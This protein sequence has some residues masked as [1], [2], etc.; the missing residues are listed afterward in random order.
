MISTT[1]FPPPSG[2]QYELRSGAHR[3]VVTEVGATLRAYTVDGVDVIDGFDLAE[4]SPGGRGQ[5]LAPWPNRVGDGRYTFGGR[6][7]QAALNEP[8]R[9]NAIHGLVRWL[10]WQPVSQ[11]ANSVLL[12][13]VLQPQP[14]YPWRLDLSLEYSVAEDGLTVSAEATNLTD[15]TA[16]FG[17]GFHP[18][19]TVG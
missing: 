2:V 10:P 17:I 8:A 12:R 7:G 6:A 16:P 11:A 14:A 3:A 19:L 1:T 9:R 13:C 18:Y 5:V 15:S 4:V